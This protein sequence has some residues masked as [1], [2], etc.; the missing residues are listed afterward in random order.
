[1][2]NTN[3]LKHTISFFILLCIAI[4]NISCGNL[5]KLFLENSNDWLTKGDANWSFS[6]N[7][8]TG[9]VKD[10]DGY[11]FSKQH[12]KNFILELEFKPDSTINS[13]VFLR[14]STDTISPTHCYEVNI[15][16]LHPNQKY[17]T[18]AIVLKSNPTEIVHTIDKWN[19]YKIKNENDRIQV[20]VND[21]LTTDI[22]D[23]TYTK[24]YISLQAK[25]TGS[26]GF[27]NVTI[28][29]LN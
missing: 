26:V 13:G 7:E 11:V 21:T 27:R 9:E 23:T 18:G 2:K 15:W 10:G 24:G 12:Y 5:E 1:M 22:K 28:K 14:C 19:T 29:T 8:L 17:R 20:W 16:D 3:Y 4:I 6:N 25:G